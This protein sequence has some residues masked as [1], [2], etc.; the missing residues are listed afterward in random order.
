MYY[1]LFT[2]IT[3]A[4]QVLQEAQKET[5]EMFISAG[6]PRMAVIGRKK[7]EAK[8]SESNQKQ[9]RKQPLKK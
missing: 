8:P 6:D 9:K 4:I 1:K 3:K 2:S 5:E 7:I